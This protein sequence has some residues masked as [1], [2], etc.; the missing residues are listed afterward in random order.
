MVEEKIEYVRRRLNSFMNVIMEGTKG[1]GSTNE[2]N[3][4]YYGLKQF[5]EFHK[6][7]N[8]LF[9]DNEL[10]PKVKT[11]EEIVKDYQYAQGFYLKTIIRE[12]ADVLDIT[13]D[14]DKTHADSPMMA[15]YQNQSSTQINLQTMNNVIECINSLQIEWEK[16]EELVKVT[17]EF[18]ENLKKKDSSKL[19]SILTKVAEISPKVAGFLLEH[20]S[21][22]GETSLLFGG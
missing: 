1:V 13:L 7:I 20:A 10:L 5:I 14:F 3:V 9:P 17:K 22:L 15:Q 18:E 16:K 19:K 2:Y 11:I 21:E 4:E 12:I 6:K 8:E